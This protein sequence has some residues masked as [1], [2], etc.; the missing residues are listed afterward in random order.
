[1]WYCICVMSGD[2]LSSVEYSYKLLILKKMRRSVTGWYEGHAWPSVDVTSHYMHSSL[3]TL[4]SSELPSSSDGPH[5]P[6]AYPTKW[7]PHFSQCSISERGQRVQCYRTSWFLQ[8]GLSYSTSLRCR[9]ALSS[10]NHREKRPSQGHILHLD[11]QLRSLTLYIC[12]FL[13]TVRA[14]VDQQLLV[15]VVFSPLA[16]VIF[17]RKKDNVPLQDGSFMTAA[18]LFGFL[19]TQ[20]TQ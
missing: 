8:S 10:R 14:W 9:L 11:S 6:H 17:G 15:Q 1:M 7:W 12:Q 5:L 16:W 3:W 4:P 13:S 20:P 19:D 2:P 18:D